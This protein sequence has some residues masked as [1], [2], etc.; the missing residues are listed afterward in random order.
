M[1]ILDLRNLNR[2][3]SKKFGNGIL[4]DSQLVFNFKPKILRDT[5]SAEISHQRALV[6]IIGWGLRY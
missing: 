6:R 5:L 4:M 3:A 1:P 2:L